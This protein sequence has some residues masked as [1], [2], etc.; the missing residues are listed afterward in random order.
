MHGDERHGDVLAGESTERID[1]SVLDDAPDEGGETLM[2]SSA[3]S[4]RLTDGET[5]ATIENRNPLARA[6]LARFGRT[7]AVDVVEHVEERWQAPRRLGFADRF[8]GAGVAVDADQM[9]TDQQDAVELPL[10]GGCPDRGASRSRP[11]V[12]G[13]ERRRRVLTRCEL[14][15]TVRPAVGWLVTLCCT[16]PLRENGVSR[17]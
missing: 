15:G 16:Y 11:G 8:A 4:G 3:L 6:P 13:R 12:A 9:A 1:V 10:V 14:A 2:L 5:T 7:S 17:R